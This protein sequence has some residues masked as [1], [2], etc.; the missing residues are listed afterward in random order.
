MGITDIKVLLIFK[1][2]NIGLDTKHLNLLN[3]LSA[4]AAIP[5]NTLPSK[6]SKEAPPPVEI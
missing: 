3:Y 1:I 5:G 4:S 6:N 2:I